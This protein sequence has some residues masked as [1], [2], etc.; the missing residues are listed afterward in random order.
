M[1]S[2]RAPPDPELTAKLT[3]LVQRLTTELGIGGGRS[4]DGLSAASVAMLS[5]MISPYDVTKV[6]TQQAQKVLNDNAPDAAAFASK[7]RELKDANVREMDKYLAVLSK[8][9]GDKD[10]LAAVTRPKAPQAFFGGDEA[11]SRPAPAPA[12]S[13]SAVSGG[14]GAS[15]A[16]PSDGD[17]EFSRGT[18]ARVS[19][20]L[21]DPSLTPPPMRPGIEYITRTPRHDQKA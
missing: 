1:A 9:V 7:Y 16:S 4:A 8:I 21:S 3:T 11:E 14:G 10:L 18:G 20:E 6:A 15:L 13:A 2:S 12:P 19:D 17:F 5:K